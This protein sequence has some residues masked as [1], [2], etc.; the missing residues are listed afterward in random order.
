MAHGGSRRRRWWIALVGLVLLVGLPVRPAGGGPHAPRSHFSD[1]PPEHPFAPDVEWAVDEGLVQGFT[2]GTYRPHLPVTRQAVAAL[3]HRLL[4]GT[5]EPP[6][7]PTFTDV[8]GD[9]PF[10]AEIEWAAAEGL[11]R[12]FTD[13]SFRPRTT[14]PRDQVAALLGRVAARADGVD[15]TEVG[16][17]AA[18]PPAPADELPPVEELTAFPDVG[19]DHAFRL[20]VHRAFGLGFVAG[21]ADGTFRPGSPVLRGEVAALL[22]RLDTWLYPPYQPVWTPEPCTVPTPAGRTTVCGRLTVPED[23]RDPGGSKVHLAVAIVKTNALAPAPDPAVYL[24]GGPGG[25]VMDGLPG[26]FKAV[27]GEQR[28]VV[29][30][31]QRGVGLSEPNLDCPERDEALW[32]TYSTAEPFADELVGLLDATEACRD[33]LADDGVDL[34]QYNSVQSA[35]DVRDLRRALGYERWNVYGVSYGTALAQQV[36]RADPFGTRSVIYDSVLP[37]L[38]LGPERLRDA[39]DRVFAH[40]WAGC[41]ADASCA[42]AH[43]DLGAEFAAVTADYDADPLALTIPD[44]QGGP[45][46]PLLLTGADL[47]GGLF[48]ALYRTDIIPLL[49]SVITAAGTRDAAIIQIIASEGLAQLTELIDG[50]FLSVECHDRGVPGGRSAVEQLILDRPDLGSLFFTAAFAYCDTW[51]V[52]V[53]PPSFQTLPVSDVPSLVLAGSYDPITPPVG[54]QVLDHVLLRSTYA[55]FP[56]Y[57][58]GILTSTNACAVSMARALLAAPGDPIDTTCLAAEGPPDFP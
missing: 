24:G 18:A 7:T 39:A 45:A 20:D 29:L 52:P 58:H 41:A 8:P 46:R 53:A 40:L 12:G 23:R 50:V 49:P 57:G 13:G 48:A 5:S 28:D 56:R 26:R 19:V 51:G 35:L 43:P 15:L 37:N 14:V 55:E 38:D 44:P 10:A 17:P 32:A 11:V 2:D 31:D 22:H 54:G 30:F 36:V 25:T 16:G 6:P 47:T 3:L 33:R 27:L 34:A 4:D 9:H 42:A 1:V 21:F